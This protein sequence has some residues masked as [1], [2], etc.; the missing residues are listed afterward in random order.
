MPTY[1]FAPRV[2]L[3]GTSKPETDKEFRDR[4]LACLEHYDARD[5]AARA[6]RHIW[7]GRHHFHPG[8]HW[9]RSETLGVMDEARSSYICGNFISTLVLALAYV[10]HTIIDALPPSEKRSPT[11]TEA[12]RYARLAGLFPDDLLDGVAVLKD[13]RNPFVHRRKVDD[14]D[15]IGKRVADRK[16]HPTPIL[17]QDAR[18]ALLLMYG[19]FRYSL[20][21]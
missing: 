11:M 18:D 14:L 9:G 3:D 16:S 13:F 17:E 4:V 19:F 8:I 6:D 15:T 21:A 5:R 7:I 12:I 10:E 20:R 2:N 1:P